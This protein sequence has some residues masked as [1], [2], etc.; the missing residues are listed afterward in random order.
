MVLHPW[1]GHLLPDRA[2]LAQTPLR[3]P[4]P[5]D[6]P[7]GAGGRRRRAAGGEP[8]APR[9]FTPVKSMGEIQ[10][11]IEAELNA[12][13]AS[14]APEAQRRTLIK[15]R[16][17]ESTAERRR[18]HRLAGAILA[19]RGREVDMA[20]LTGC[21]ESRGAHGL[22]GRRDRLEHLQVPGRGRD[23]EHLQGDRPHQ[24]RPAGNRRRG[25]G[26]VPHHDPGQDLH[27]PGRHRVRQETAHQIGGARGGPQDHRP[28]HQGPG[29]LRRILQHRA[30][31]PPAAQQV[32]P[33]RA[34]P[35][36]RPDPG[37]PERLPGRRPHLQPARG[38]AR[39]TWSC[40]WPTCRRSA[41]RWCGGS[42]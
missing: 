16:I 27:R 21:P 7:A 28:P 17:Q 1:F 40:A 12:E 42:P 23:P 30:G 38:P 6:A 24:A 39:P 9:K 34:P 15:K 32:H 37:P 8:S 36:H 20:K 22:P 25:A 18:D 2:A 4:E 35:D 41:P 11:E 5:P 10:A 29:I 31:Q 13:G 3:R 14:G 19:H 26:G 33:E